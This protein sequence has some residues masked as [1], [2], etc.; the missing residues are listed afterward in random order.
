MQKTLNILMATLIALGAALPASVVVAVAEPFISDTEGTRPSGIPNAGEDEETLNWFGENLDID[1]GTSG[2]EIMVKYNCHEPGC[3][4]ATPNGPVPDV[5]VSVYITWEY[6][7]GGA[8]YPAVW[9]DVND[10][11]PGVKVTT[12][13]PYYPGGNVVATCS[14][15]MENQF[16]DASDIWW[17]QNAPWSYVVTSNI[18]GMVFST[19]N[20][21]VSIEATLSLNPIPIP[22]EDDN[23]SENY[24][25]NG[26]IK[27]GTIQATNSAGVVGWTKDMTGRPAIGDWLAIQFTQYWRNNGVGDDLQTAAIKYGSNGIWTLLTTASYSSVTCVDNRL[28]VQGIEETWVYL[29]V[30][31]TGT[32]YLRVG[33]TDSNW[34]ANTGALNFAVYKA[35]YTPPATGCGLNYVIGDYVGQRTASANSSA[36]ISYEFINTD[37]LDASGNP[38]DRIYVVETSGTWSNNGMVDVHGG[39]RVMDGNP[40]PFQPMETY[41]GAVCVETLDPLGHVRVYFTVDPQIPDYAFRAEDAA[42]YSDNTGGLT[43]LFYE[44]AYL[45]VDNPP[46]VDP[47][48]GSYASGEILTTFTLMATNPAYRLATLESGHYYG[49]KTANGPWQD[50]SVDSYEIAMSASV[51]MPQLWMEVSDFSLCTDYDGQYTLSYFYAQPGYKYYVRVNDGDGNMTNNTGNMGIIIYD[52]TNEANNWETCADAYTMTQMTTDPAL[53]VIPANQISG[54]NLLYISTGGSYAFEI[55]GDYAWS[56]PDVTADYEAEVCLVGPNG[57]GDWI[58]IAEAQ[59]QS[60]AA[61]VV[62]VDPGKLLYRMY[63]TAEGG[64][65]LRVHDTDSFFSENSGKLTYKLYTTAYID[66]DDPGTDGTDGTDPGAPAAWQASCTTACLRPLGLLK[67]IPI[68]FGTLGTVNFPV[69]D[70]AGW[71]DWAICTVVQYFMWCPEHTAALSGIRMTFGENVEPMATF[72]VLFNFIEETRAQIETLSLSPVAA[73]P[74]DDITGEGGGPVGSVT[75]GDAPQAPANP[76]DML[77]PGLDRTD[78][79]WFGGQVDL[80]IGTAVDP[81]K[82]TTIAA[83]EERMNPYV[84]TGAGGAVCDLHYMVSNTSLFIA[85]ITIMDVA[86]LVFLGFKYLPAYVRRWFVLFKG[87]ADTV[88]AIVDAL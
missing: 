12:D 50:N 40:D 22:T 82:A 53:T 75:V 73:S 72:N 66:P 5:Y 44:A 25:P 38:G 65:K 14:A 7:G 15:K 55:T 81:N 71:V 26:L 70:V 63:F 45:P 48:A 9:I 8:G 10:N 52:A 41:S 58:P 32:P 56:D 78:N 24:L 59:Q 60:L 29:Q 33:D 16:Y 79:P 21:H 86:L 61:C 68:S 69:P 43:F 80:N 31:S 64:Y 11:E 6:A 1:P 23:C 57:C 76:V 4:L 34:S 83:C 74:F 37:V 87:N 27:T 62:L 35:I 17:S 77:M 88:T 42:S 84:G 47:C 54:T 20:T 3:Y 67:Q 28:N 85:L 30:T 46:E 39:M 51:G 2:V 19:A 13:C 36:G 49:I 18:S